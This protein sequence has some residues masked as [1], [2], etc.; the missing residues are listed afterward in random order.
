M[1]KL[2]Y[3]MDPTSPGGV[4]VETSHQVLQMGDLCHDA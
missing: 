4:I 2:P 3:Q 1:V